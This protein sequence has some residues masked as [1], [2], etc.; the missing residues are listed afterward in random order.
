MGTTRDT[1][2]GLPDGHLMDTPS[3]TPRETTRDIPKG[4][5]EGQPEGHPERHPER[6]PGP[7]RGHPHHT[8]SGAIN[9]LPGAG[10]GPLLGGAL[11]GCPCQLS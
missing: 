1:P 2:K 6:Q 11:L 3:D 8:Q 7:G 4:H 10:P 9:I 5:P